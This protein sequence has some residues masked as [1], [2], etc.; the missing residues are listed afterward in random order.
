MRSSVIRIAVTRSVSLGL[1]SHFPK[2]GYEGMAAKRTSAS[3]V[4]AKAVA[5]GHRGVLARIN[6]DGWRALRLLSVERDTT[7]Q[8]LAIEAFNDLLTKHGKRPIVSG[9]SA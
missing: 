2:H 9:S 1:C 4:A 8:A 3:K 6:V 7:M 5:S